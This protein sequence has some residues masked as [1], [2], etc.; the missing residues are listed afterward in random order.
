MNEDKI[1]FST[2]FIRSLRLLTFNHELPAPVFGTA[3]DEAKEALI[4]SDV[5]I[6]PSN[7]SSEKCKNCAGI[8]ADF[9]QVLC[10]M[11]EN[12]QVSCTS[13]HLL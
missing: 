2:P 11:A 1:K 10:D 6:A 9:K 8:L 5:Q 3:R 4:K 13:K 7:F 12:L